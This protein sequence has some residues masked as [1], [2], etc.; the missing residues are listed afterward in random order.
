MPSL[1]AGSDREQDKESTSVQD[2]FTLTNTVYEVALLITPTNGLVCHSEKFNRQ[3]PSV[4]LNPT[5]ST[6]ERKK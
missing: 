5:M 2:T 3:T 1:L 4:V 6:Y